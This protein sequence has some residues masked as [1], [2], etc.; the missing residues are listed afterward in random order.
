MTPFSTVLNNI[1]ECELSCL[2][3]Q[4]LT[5]RRLGE[6]EHLQTEIKASSERTNLKQRGV[7]WQFQIDDAHTKVKR[8]YPK[9][10]S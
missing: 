4:S 9:I 6:L 10:Q 2:T 7:D 8:L 3:S 5:G 1:A